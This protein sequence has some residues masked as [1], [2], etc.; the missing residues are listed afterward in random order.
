MRLRRLLFTAASTLALV[1]TASVAIAQ[2]GPAPTD[3]P[4][5]DTQA[6]SY[7]RDLVSLFPSTLDG[8]ALGV[9]DFSG[10]E[11]LSRS[12]PESPEGAV[13]LGRAEALLAAAGKSVEDLTVA[14]ALHV[15]SPGNVATITA[16]Q[17]RGSEAYELVEPI[18]GLLRAD[19]GSPRLRLKPIADRT[20]LEVR[21]ASAPGTY[22]VTV[23]PVGDTVWFV[24][25]GGSLR[26]QILEALPQA[27]PRS[28]AYDLAVIFPKRIGGARRDTLYVASGWRLPLAT[29][30]P[31]DLEGL[32]EEVYLATGAG[33]YDVATASGMSMV[34]GFRAMLTAYQIA[35]ADEVVMHQVLEEIL[36]PRFRGG[37]ARAEPVEVA[38]RD[39]LLVQVEG[40]RDDEP[41][42]QVHLYVS[43]DTIWALEAEEPHL[44]ELLEQLP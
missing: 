12:D 37:E 3:G 29:M 22:P 39:L 30:F 31:F 40:R 17:L 19:I 32:A 15:P 28:A 33:Y 25:A 38:G 1:L 6:R 18:I 14:T 21:D 8:R 5:P 42:E 7:A 13:A 36:L 27:P 24:D 11:W 44:T 10:S 34:V 35:G 41:T 16:V 4:S 43:G 20:V 2:D 26:E 9:E 23:Y